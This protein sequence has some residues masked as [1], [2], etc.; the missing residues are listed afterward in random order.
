MS[1]ASLTGARIPHLA[2]APYINYV[3][4]HLKFNE[5]AGATTFVDSSPYHS[6]YTQQEA[7]LL[8]SSSSKGNPFGAGTAA[9][10]GQA[11]S[12]GIGAIAA[13]AA[14][15][16]YSANEPFVIEG[17]VYIVSVAGTSFDG[18]CRTTQNTAARTYGLGT[19]GSSHTLEWETGV[20]SSDT[21]VSVPSGSWVYLAQSYDGT[22]LRAY[23][24]GSLIA[25]SVQSNISGVSASNNMLFGSTASQI[26]SEECYMSDWRVTLGVSR[27]YTGSTIPVPTKYFPTS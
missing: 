27:G 5:T 9:N 6:T 21:T 12:A 25:S 3:V 8:T 11:P 14:Q 10:I 17:W 20:T 7:H 16:T 24:N 13:T 15:F 22:T 18:L 4:A 1:L 2:G 19:H 26:F 23:I